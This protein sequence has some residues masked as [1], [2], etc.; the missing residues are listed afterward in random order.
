MAIASSAEARCEATRS[1]LQR[2]SSPGVSGGIHAYTA[3]SGTPRSEASSAANAIAFFAP[4]LPSTPTTTA[5]LGS[6]LWCSG[7]TATGQCDTAAIFTA[8]VPKNE[9]ASLLPV[10]APRITRSARFEASSTSTIGCPTTAVPVTS[11][12]NPEARAYSHS[13]ASICSEAFWASLRK[14]TLSLKNESSATCSNSTC[15]PFWAARA[16]PQ[17]SAARLCSEPSTPMMYFSAM[18]CP[19]SV[20]LCERFFGLYVA[21][22]QLHRVAARK[23]LDDANNLAAVAVLVVVPDVDDGA[24]ASG[25]GSEAV[26]DTGSV[27]ADEVH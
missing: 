7:I 8:R 13:A 21:H 14:A 25:D 2:Y 4:S 6:S 26:D 27:R 5:G 17:S 16:R 15:A 11:P 10:C 12:L 19:F 1:S 3:M 20:I 22:R 23:L 18:R 9:P 24:I